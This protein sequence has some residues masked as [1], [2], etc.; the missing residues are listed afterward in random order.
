ME[1]DLDFG[2]EGTERVGNTK[3][4]GRVLRLAPLSPS[5]EL[6]LPVGIMRP[7]DDK[8]YREIV[9]DEMCGRDEENMAKAKVRRNA[10]LASTTLLRRCVQSIPGLIP[11]K[12]N[13]LAMIDVQPVREWMTQIDR[14]FLLVAILVLSGKE[15][16]VVRGYCEKCE[17]ELEEDVTFSEMSLY[18]WPEDLPMS[19]SGLLPKG[20]KD[21]QGM[22]HREFTLA[23]PSGKIQENVIT[24]ARGNS[25]VASTLLMSACLTKLGDYDHID[26]DMATSLRS[27][28]RAHIGS[29]YND[30]FPGLSLSNTV[31]CDSCGREYDSSVDL[32]GFFVEALGRGKKKK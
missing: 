6:L 23:F 15:E 14:D 31:N 7:G 17:E 24:Q 10:S 11:E 27:L 13:P 2:P 3:P 30:S 16:T 22:V 9:I 20:F 32:S 25:G 26:S 12:E 29:L 8:R 21:R 18:D 28:D 5:N 4:A 1:T 19:L